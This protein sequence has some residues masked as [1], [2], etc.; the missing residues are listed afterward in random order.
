MLWQTDGMS[1]PDIR[2]VEW[3]A[4]SSV[5][6]HEERDF[7]RWLADNLELLAEALDLDGLELVE[8]ESKVESFRADIVARADD[9][10]D[11]PLPVV[12]ENQ[13]GRTDHDHLGKLITYLAR[14]GR[15]LGVWVVEEI[16][17]A[18]LAAIDFLNRIGDESV[19]FSL[20]AVRFADAPGGGHYVDFDVAAQPNLWLKRARSPAAAPRHR[21]ERLEFIEA[22]YE[23][24]EEPLR[25]G[26]WADVSLYTRRPHIRLSL[27]SWHP[28]SGSR[29]RISLRA[30]LS[31]FVL[32]H[33]V[34]AGS[35]DASYEIVEQLRECYASRWEEPLPDGTEMHWHSATSRR[36]PANDQI[37]AVNP[38]GGYQALD[39]DAAAAWAIEV[40]NSW[41]TLLTD[42]PS[43]DVPPDC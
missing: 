27:P 15:G 8:I 22:V 4:A 37:Q 14:Q 9:G 25:A 17:E 13:Y 28:L 5:L 29:S 40:C 21:P 41:A 31:E 42:D 19:G 16:H 38:D 2:K 33:I 11:E 36:N 23:Q 35:F 1:A 12:I 20:V 7:T 3:V 18:H 24:V 34:R 6:R 43:P 10:T 26:P 39:P 30:N 32:R